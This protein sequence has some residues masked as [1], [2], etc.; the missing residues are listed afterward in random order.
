MHDIE[1]LSKTQKVGKHVIKT[2]VKGY[3]HGK[4]DIAIKVDGKTISQAIGVLYGDVLE[5]LVHLGI[6]VQNHLN[7]RDEAKTLTGKL[8]KLGFKE[9]E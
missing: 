5:G 3:I 4:V 9:E 1:R 8:L 7:M 2:I 6:A